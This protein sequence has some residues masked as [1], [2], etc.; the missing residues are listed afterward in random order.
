V[1]RAPNRHSPVCPPL[2]IARLHLTFNVRQRARRLQAMGAEGIALEGHAK[3]AEPVLEQRR[4]TRFWW[5]QHMWTSLQQHGVECG[6]WL[7]PV[8]RGSIEIR[9]IYVGAKQARAGGQPGRLG[10][11]HNHQAL[12]KEAFAANGHLQPP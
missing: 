9:T 4:D 3:T 12:T 2:R 11:G 7:L 8:I 1:L 10:R 5:N 6:E